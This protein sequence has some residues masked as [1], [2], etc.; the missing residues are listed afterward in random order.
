MI[1]NLSNNIQVEIIKDN[2]FNT[3]R[4][5]IDFFRTIKSKETT[6]RKLLSNILSH[7]CQ[8]YPRMIDISRKTMDLYGADLNCRNRQ[9]GNLN[10][11][12]FSME[13]INGDDETVDGLSLFKE[14]FEL[15]EKLILT[16]ILNRDKKGFSEDVFS[17][18]K[19][20]LVSNLISMK[21]NKEL[22]SYLKLWQ[23]LF[24]ENPEYTIPVIGDLSELK[25]TNNEQV[26][27]HYQEMLKDDAVKIT[28]VSN[29]DE[30]KILEHIKNSNLSKLSNQRLLVKWNRQ[31]IS[32]DKPIK[33]IEKDKINQSRI[34]IGYEIN[35]LKFKNNIVYQLFN[36]ALGGDDQSL[37][38]QNVREKNSLAYSINS[39]Y[40]AF[41]NIVTIYA[42]IDGQEVDN[43]INLIDDQIDELQENEI[44]DIALKHI[45]KILITK[46]KLASDRITSDLNKSVWRYLK[47]QNLIDDEEYIKIV[48]ETTKKDIQNVA[49]H[50]KKVATYILVGE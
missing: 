34:S 23:L 21:D 10:D 50:L 37:L 42:G 32:L 12:N 29:L 20:N 13:I 8:E 4:F 24:K 49:R 33:L 28:V 9:W 15:L 48:N 3:T 5:E 1:E 35:G 31:L 27:Q 16:P 22:T 25:S 19:D 40:N 38:F 44:S 43:A 46:R 17:V 36:L 18:E 26:F 14:S 41:S 7:S 11:M 6:I 30:N 39:Q 47:P 2:K 45:K